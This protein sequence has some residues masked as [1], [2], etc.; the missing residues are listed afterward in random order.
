MALNRC[1]NFRDSFTVLF[2]VVTNKF[3][4][5]LEFLAIYFICVYLGLF[6]NLTRFVCRQRSIV[7]QDPLDLTLIHV[8]VT[9]NF[10]HHSDRMA[11]FDHWAQSL[12]KFSPVEVGF[13][14]T[15]LRLGQGSVNDA[16]L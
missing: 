11:T 16:L 1:L 4:Y 6:D 3:D 2:A 13:H 15:D 14:I 9:A 12:S 10:T 7:G 8:A 5:L